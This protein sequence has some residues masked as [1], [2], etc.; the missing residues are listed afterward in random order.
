MKQAETQ[1]TFRAMPS[2]SQGTSDDIMFLKTDVDQ[3]I[4]YD[5]ATYRLDAVRK[6]LDF[7]ST[8]GTDK[9]G[10]SSDVSMV[11][12]AAGILVTDAMAIL[13]GLKKNRRPQ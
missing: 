7:A 10:A 9:S 13:D 6:L 1:N 2:F 12:D 5:S 4:I 3:G 11:T 8:I